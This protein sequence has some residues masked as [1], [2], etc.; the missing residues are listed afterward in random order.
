MGKV[1]CSCRAWHSDLQQHLEGNSSPP[2]S[3][4]FS[5]AASEWQLTYGMLQTF[6]FQGAKSG[7]EA[8]LVAG[9]R[10]NEGSVTRSAQWRV[11][12]NG[13][14]VHTGRSGPA[15]SGVPMCVLWGSAPGS[16]TWA[17]Y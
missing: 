11:L 6:P 4:S 13:S 16:Q 7:G 9:C 1:S 17:L 10:I 2:G 5:T 3:Q 14:P 8:S 12:R 15:V